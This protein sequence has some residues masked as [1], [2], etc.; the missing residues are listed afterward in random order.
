MALMPI[1]MLLASAA[2]LPSGS[3]SMPRNHAAARRINERFSSGGAFDD[4]HSAGV[5][6]H[7]F[8]DLEDSDEVW[9][10]CTSGWCTK[11][12]DR[13]SASLISA[14]SPPTADGNIGLF[15]D[16]EGVFSGGF[17][18]APSEMKVLC[19]YPHDG[20]T[21]DRL[22]LNGDGTAINP[23][24]PCVPGCGCKDSE[25]KPCKNSCIAHPPSPASGVH[26]CAWP[27]ANLSS[28]L[29]IQEDIQKDI[30]NELVLDS[31][32]WVANLPHSIEAV[33]YPKGCSQVTE[34]RARAAHAALVQHFKIETPL[35]IL[36]TSNWETPFA[37]AKKERSPHF[38]P[39][40]ALVCPSACGLCPPA[41]SKGAC[42]HGNQTCET[43]NWSRETCTSRYG[44]WCTHSGPPEPPP[45]LPP[46]CPPPRGRYIPQH[47]DR[48][49]ASSSKNAKKDLYLVL[50]LDDIQVGYLAKQQAS[51]VDWALQRDIKLNLGVIT[52]SASTDSKYVTWPTD[53]P[54]S[55]LCDD[56]IV[57]AILSAYEAGRVLNDDDEDDDGDADDDGDDDDDG[58]ES[59]A[60]IE[61]FDHA[62]FHNRWGSD[63]PLTAEQQL[64]DMVKSTTALRTA[65][66]NARI[67][68]F[69]P[70]RNLAD[71]ATLDAMRATGLNIISSEGTLGCHPWNGP[72]PRYNYMFAPCQTLDAAG[73]FCIPPNDTYATRAGFQPLLPGDAF[74]P[75]LLGPLYSTPTGAANSKFNDVA[76]GLSVNDTL[77]VGACGCVGEICPIISAAKN[78]AVKSNGLLWTVLMMHPQT[79]FR[80]SASYVEWLDEFLFEARALEEY[81]VHFINFQDLVEL[82]SPSTAFDSM[83]PGK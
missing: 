61:L 54:G 4:V 76:S 60:L 37:I 24:V 62:Y 46:P 30:Y 10:P 5:T 35:L 13:I 78:N 56:P 29:H 32:T 21:M 38:V 82:R 79:K 34:D 20:G 15:K 41:G 18:A 12:S 43:S 36:D 69:V 45:P 6:M 55:K 16:S 11:Y 23:G 65:Y 51:I 73:P 49:A 22:C 33:F 71:T 7:Q 19:S 8:D 83:P 3:L 63:W 40:T 66:P 58:D 72:P 74:L 68:T 31:K 47:N 28:M 70:P 17:I 80:C 77:G 81:N 39:G 42:C 27:P 1:G 44:T 14:H 48:G 50:R 25:P 26:Q 53:C 52:G 75:E 67:R 2:H 64:D 57:T 9:R 59:G